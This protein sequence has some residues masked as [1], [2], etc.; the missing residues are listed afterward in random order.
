MR[1]ISLIYI[2]SLIILL[3][4][5]T[6]SNVD[7][8]FQN[9]FVKY[10]GEDGNQEGVDLLV[11]AD[12]SMILL[13]N[14]SS[15]TNPITIPFMV[16]IDPLGNVLWKRQLGD[17]NETAVDVTLDR[18][19]NLIVVS[20][21]GEEAN[22]RIRVFRI[23]QQGK[24]IDSIIIEMGEKQ[25]AK[26]ITQISD[27]N[28]LIAG[29]AEADPNINPE[30]PTPPAN[31]DDIIVLKVDEALKQSTVSLRQG[32][33]HVGAAV[34]IFETVLNDSTKYLVFGDSD[35]PYKTGVYKR[36]FEVISINNAGVQ[37][38]RSVSGVGGEIQIAATII[39]TPASLTEGYLMVGTTYV[40]NSTASNIY[41]TQYSKALDIKRLDMSILLG[42]RLEGVSAA[43]GDPGVFFILANEIRDNN[44][45]DIFLLKLASDGAVIGFTS[46][47][48]LEGDDIA[49]SVRVLADG[50]VALFGTMELET[51]KKMVLITISPEGKFAN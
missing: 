38:I 17:I 40:Q 42:R 50:R 2:T 5:D 36:A 46:F 13:G 35:R 30:L 39:E 16:R 48:T 29:Y 15:Q 6:A 45:R 49:G 19:G 31:V 44:K 9:Y 28:F 24:G 51:Q 25:V 12:G 33:E 26:S 27:N 23:D 10:Y 18:L 41:I 8:V 11:Q 4:C 37:G 47:G 32:G 22:S 21:I 14:S 20:N 43:T 34:K 3:S 1:Q 7:P